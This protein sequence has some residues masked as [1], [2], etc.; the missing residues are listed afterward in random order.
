MSAMRRL[1]NFEARTAWVFEDDFDT[2]QIIGVAN[3][4]VQDDDELARLAMTR[5]DPDFRTAVKPGDVLVAG[6]NFG[7]GHPHAVGMRAMR[8]LGIHAVV[9]ESFFPSYWL[10]EIGAGFLQIVC[11]GISSS[12]ERWD[13]LSVNFAS[14]FIT[15]ERTGERLAIDQYS[16][17]DVDVLLAGGLINLLMSERSTDHGSS[18]S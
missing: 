3:L 13:R 18:P 2:D 14:G 15:V 16:E 5:F 6:M 17:R 8:R 9:A 12:V 11:P 4:K 7:Y 1:K 10:N